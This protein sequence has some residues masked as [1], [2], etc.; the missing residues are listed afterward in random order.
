MHNSWILILGAAASLLA[1]PAIAE[2]P[3]SAQTA[4]TV[5]ERRSDIVA[6]ANQAGKFGTLL[7]ALKAADL[8][9]TLQGSGPFTVFAPTDEAFAKLP[10]GTVEALLKDKQ[11]LRSILTLHVVPGSLKAQS[12]VAGTAL[13]SVQGQTL[14]ARVVDGQATVNGAAILQ[15]DLECSNGVIHVIDSVLL[16]R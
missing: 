6:T 4:Q 11:K 8:Q 15:T 1:A 13:N 10:P 2:C 5:A 7:A 12:V 9:E 16:P 14:Q 3:G